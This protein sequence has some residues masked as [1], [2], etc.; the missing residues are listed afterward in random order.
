MWRGLCRNIAASSL[1]I[2]EIL[3]RYMSPAC[4]RLVTYYCQSTDVELLVACANH[5]HIF[6][7]M[8]RCYLY[9]D[10]VNCLP[11]EIVDADV[12]S[13][14]TT[15]GTWLV[16]LLRDVEAVVGLSIGL[17]DDYLVEVEP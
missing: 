15:I 13:I 2:A 8:S 9:A 11:N 4:A 10:V 7:V 14:T 3:D 16:Y 6:H 17:L 1:C 5:C 12:C